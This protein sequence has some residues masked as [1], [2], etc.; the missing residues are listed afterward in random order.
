M[1]EGFGLPPL[2]AL[3]CGCV[4]FSSLNHA[5]ADYGD[6]GHTVHQIGCGRL[7]VDLERIQA[8]VDSPERW[9]PAV[10]RLEAL[11]QECSG[12]FLLERWRV[13]FAHL[14]ALEAGLGPYLSSP[15]TWRLR[16]QQLLARLQRVVNRL[17]GWPAR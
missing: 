14:D 15:P 5:L 9:R 12:A 11:L 6:P 17:P 16:L 2:E 13:V 10:D 4:V 3:A 8:A 1:T 7:S